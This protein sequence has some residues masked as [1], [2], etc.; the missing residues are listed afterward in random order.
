MPASILNLPKELLLKIIHSEDSTDAT[1]ACFGQTCR[2]LHDI[3]QVTV[4]NIQLPILRT[5]MRKHELVIYKGSGS[6]SMKGEELHDV[7]D[8]FKASFDKIEY[9]FSLKFTPQE[10][11]SVHGLIF[12][13][14]AVAQITIILN[15]YSYFA[16]WYK[17]LGI[18]IR[19]SSEKDKSR[20]TVVGTPLGGQGFS[21]FG[22][23]IRASSEKDKAHLTVKG[24]P[25]SSQGFSVAPAPKTWSLTDIGFEPDS[26]QVGVMEQD[27]FLDR[28]VNVTTP[29]GIESL[30][31]H[32][33]LPFYEGCFPYTLRALN[34]GC[35]TRL[36]LQNDSLDVSQW[37]NIFPLIF[38]PLL[39]ELDVDNPYIP[40]QDFFSFLRRHTTI[41]HLNLS[42][43]VPIAGS[44]GSPEG[45]DFLHRL[46]VISGIP[47]NLSMFLSSERQLFPSLRSVTL[48]RYPWLTAPEPEELNN[49]LQ[50]LAQRKRASIHLCIEFSNP[51]DVSEWVSDK[52]SETRSLGC[53]KNL[54]IV[55]CGFQMPQE[56][57]G[58]FFSWVSLFPSIQELEITQIVP[59]RLK[60][61]T[62]SLNV[63]WDSCP[64]LQSI[65]VGVKTYKRPTQS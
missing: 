50:N 64:E 36:S 47:N 42:C 37:S 61:W 60:S 24:T 12:H 62:G 45:A 51:G 9:N 52:K 57:C 31:L 4:L 27:G 54:E 29:R 28:G 14:N 55:I 58:S 53:V 1:I 23:I 13:A 7:Q 15:S 16:D 2:R 46:E 65:T 41:T 44:T 11:G 35:I 38:M 25:I 3:C 10:I 17:P 19:A 20:L 39:S 59:L 8:I 21:P 33:P 5:L 40:F 6:I 56:M 43:S 34:G 22:I 49:I 26:C 48:K 63:L 18:I 30:N 32:S